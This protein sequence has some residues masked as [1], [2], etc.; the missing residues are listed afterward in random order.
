MSSKIVGKSGTLIAEKTSVAAH[1]AQDD[2]GCTAPSNEQWLNEATRLERLHQS[3]PSQQLLR[4]LSYADYIQHVI[5]V[6]RPYYALSNEHEII[7]TDSHVRKGFACTVQAEMPLGREGGDMIFA[8][9]G[10]HMAIAGS[11][12]A[13]L[14]NPVP[15]K[16]YYLALD[17][18]LARCPFEGIADALFGTT[19]VAVEGCS[20]ICCQCMEITARS[21][22]C[23]IRLESSHTLSAWHLKVQYA[24]IPE[25]A[26]K[27]MYPPT[28]QSQGLLSPSAQS[29]Y[30]CFRGLPMPPKKL[31]AQ[32]ASSQTPISVQ[33]EARMPP[34]DAVQCAGHFDGNPALPIA[35]MC[36]Y[37]ADLVGQS[38]A[39]LVGVDIPFNP[40]RTTCPFQNFLQLN[41]WKI[42]AKKLVFAGSHG[43][44][45]ACKAW[46]VQGDR[47]AHR[48]LYG[49]ELTIKAE[50]SQKGIAI[51]SGTFYLERGAL[52]DVVEDQG[53]KHQGN[54]SARLP[55]RL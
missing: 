54:G 55:S 34:P 23:E 43:L 16:F 46:L 12:A 9:A 18:A 28:G 30:A 14:N 50:D 41:T 22:T 35:F 26:F 40:S 20:V 19:D 7:A 37:M 17:A 48:S 38:I 53:R 51:A 13:A 47:S 4:P 5:D 3:D 29:P 31:I 1:H 36:A 2:Q 15:G 39:D 49:C 21:A 8:E 32:G 27:K 52:V 25:K 45:M 6:S 24:V 11:I 42:N 10:R 33:M 44:I